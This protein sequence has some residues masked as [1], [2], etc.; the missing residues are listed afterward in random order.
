MSKSQRAYCFTAWK[1]PEMN[2]NYIRYMIYQKEK[3]P[4][5]GTEHYQGYAEFHKKITI[6]TFKDLIND[7]KA[8]CE[9]RIGTRDE[10]RLYCMKEETRLEPYVEQGKWENGGQGSR[11]DL[12]NIIEHF[13]QGGTDYD[14]L[15]A[16]PEEHRKH[17]TWI[18][19]V[20]IILKQKKADDCLKEKVKD[21][22]PNEHQVS[23]LNSIDTQTTR[24]V[25]WVYD[26]EGNTGKSYLSDYLISQGWQC[27]PNSK[28]EH[29]T[30]AIQP[31][32][33]GFIFDFSRSLQERVNYDII[34]QVKNGRIFSSKYQS[35][36][37]YFPVPKIIVMANFMPDMTKLSLDRWKIIVPR[38]NTSLEESF[39]SMG[40]EHGPESSASTNRSISSKVQKPPC[41]S[42][43]HLGK[44]D[45]LLHT[46][47][48]CL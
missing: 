24:E 23:Y 45:C 8:H 32:A 5:T 18:D 7:P 39:E 15:K 31:E 11:T 29:L 1:I 6:P 13:E 16:H 26:K 40:S 25:T 4:K 47:V 35:A 30:Y 44:Y 36:T 20:K 21:F 14:F 22:V 19:K 12:H 37:K 42:D 48:N 41:A 3:C 27:F 9:R 33:K 17:H 46:W 38:G 28:N 43:S 10:A 34:E 2:I